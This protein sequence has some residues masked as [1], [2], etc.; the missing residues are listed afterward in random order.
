MQ[1]PSVI[2]SKGACTRSSQQQ[3]QRSTVP[4][5]A[6][7]WVVRLKCQITTTA[8]SS[9]RLH[10]ISLCRNSEILV[11]TDIVTGQRFRPTAVSGFTVFLIACVQG[12]LLLSSPVHVR[13]DFF[14]AGPQF[15]HLP[16]HMRMSFAY[17]RLTMLPLQ[18]A[19]ETS[20][21]LVQEFGGVPSRLS[22]HN[23]C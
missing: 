12:F 13:F 11:P 22:V 20:G 8:Y 4:G 23:R 5:R 18:L 16:T 21:F 14:K 2:P 6:S 7:S 1:T 3:C 9:E 10:H 17:E 15:L 19:F